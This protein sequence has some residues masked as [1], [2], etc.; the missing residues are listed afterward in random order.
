[1]VAPHCRG[2][3]QCNGA[4]SNTWR[5]KEDTVNT[6]ICSLYGLKPPRLLWRNVPRGKM[7]FFGQNLKMCRGGKK[8]DK[9]GEVRSV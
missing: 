7:G 4:D 8:E 1:M 3:M 2:M 9:R 5:I 6:L